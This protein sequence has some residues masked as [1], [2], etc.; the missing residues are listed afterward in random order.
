MPASG[1]WVF[2]GCILGECNGGDGDSGDA[3][4]Q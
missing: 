4:H 1:G 2:A 3:F